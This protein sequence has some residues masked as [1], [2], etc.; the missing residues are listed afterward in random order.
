MTFKISL[1]I[2]VVCSVAVGCTA[3][4]QTAALA[5]R[6]IAGPCQPAYGASMCTWADASGSRIVS[7]GAT[8]PLAAIENSPVNTQMVWPPVAAAVVALPAEARAATGIDHLTFYW[9][10]HGHPPKPFLTPHY[11]FHFYTISD[12]ARKA[13]DCANKT[14]PQALA[15]GYALRDMD[16]PGIG[17][18][19][20]LCV[21]KMGM[22]SVTTADFDATT[23]F[24]GTMV[25]GYY[26]AK[27][28][29]FEPMISRTM[30][31]EK[32]SFTLPL[33]TPPGVDPAIHFPTKFEAVWDPSIPGYRFVFSGFPR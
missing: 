19:T 18:L 27:P 23:P 3:H 10:E 6:R 28:I 26:N 11:D 24:N 15:A 12:S 33:V 13:I 14:K 20:G 2:S 25:L 1:Y 8:V 16:I 17:F 9:E 7:V 29:F 5:T 22:H 21:A 32:K 30:L 31:M 4:V